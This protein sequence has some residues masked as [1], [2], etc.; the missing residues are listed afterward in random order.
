[1]AA[2]PY[3]I[4]GQDPAGR[5]CCEGHTYPAALVLM[6]DDA[7]SAMLDAAEQK[8]FHPEV[9]K[10]LFVAKRVRMQCLASRVSKTTVQDRARLIIVISWLSSDLMT[11]PLH[12]KAFSCLVGYLT[13][14]LVLV[15]DVHFL[16]LLYYDSILYADM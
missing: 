3:R 6:T 12:C 11:M 5:A 13:G 2:T 7:E 8:R 1:M 16:T 4:S 14:N 9:A 10:I 15:N